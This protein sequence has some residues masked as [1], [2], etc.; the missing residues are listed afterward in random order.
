MFSFSEIVKSYIISKKNPGEKLSYFDHYIGGL[1]AGL[2]YSIWAGPIENI[3]IIM[4]LQKK[5]KIY[6]HSIDC[7]RKVIAQYG[8]SGFM[9]GTT[10]SCIAYI[11]FHGVSLFVPSNQ[12]KKT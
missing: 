3:R 9:R 1:A 2:G 8:M 5:E 4:Q 7:G 11:P 6:K 10:A 12:L